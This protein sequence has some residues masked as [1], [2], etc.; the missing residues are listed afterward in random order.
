MYLQRLLQINIATLA[1]LG[2]LLLGMGRRDPWLPLLVLLAAITSVWLTDVTGWFRLNRTVANAAALVAVVLSARELRYFGGDQQIFSITNLLIYL[3]LIL[4][5]QEKDDRTYLQLVML[6]LLQVVV[7][8]VFSQGV[9]FGLLL[10]VY[11]LVGLSALALLFLY[12]QWNRY[13]PAAELPPSSAGDGRWPLAG[14][15]STFTSSPAGRGRGGVGRELFGRLGMMGLGTLALTILLFFT[16]PRFGRTAYRGAAVD[17]RR[18]VGFSDTVTLGELGSVIESREEVMR[19]WLTDQPGST[20][21][22]VQGELYL[23]GAI[24]THYQNGQWEYRPARAK[25][26]P[27]APSP[28]SLKHASNVSKQKGLSSLSSPP[29]RRVIRQRIDVEPLDRDDLFCIWPFVRLGPDDNVEFDSR[30][31]R[32]KRSTGLHAQ[33][34]RYELGTTAMVDGVQ[35]E[36][37]PCDELPDVKPLLQLPQG[38]CRTELAR[39]WTDEAWP[40]ARMELAQELAAKFHDPKL[41]QYSLERQDRESDFNP[42][43]DPVVDFINNN[44]RGHCEYFAT[45]LALLL[46]TRGIPSRVVV[47][48]KCE[49]FNQAGE[50]YR[51]RQWH[52]HAWVEAYLEKQHLPEELLRRGPP[53][54][55][56]KG[57]WLRL[58][59]TPGAGMHAGADSSLLGRIKKAWHWI[60]DLWSDYIIEMD[61]QRQREAIYAPVARAV[62][63]AIS[64]LCDPHWWRGAIR[65][66]DKTLNLTQ[67]SG[68][69]W[70][71]VALMVLAGLPLLI[72]GGRLLRRV[73]GRLWGRLAGRADSAFGGRQA[74]VEFYRRLETLLARHGL[75]RSVGQTQHE[76]ATAAGT[77][78]AQITGQVRLASLP[79]QVAEAF[80]RVRFG[81]LPLDSPQAQ[82]VEHALTQLAAC[83]FV[84]CRGE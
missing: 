76:F 16:V 53:R 27:R 4:L 20:T 52:A 49:E 44:P 39:T 2:A 84:Q 72:F 21:Y 71:W 59:P 40:S 77:R 55:W 10:V 37:V 9:W 75:V 43:V 70:L 18:V 23:R 41:F 29:N 81:R 13:R 32:L 31:Q 35:E 11:M 46:R 74:E 36:L 3:Q 6:S 28:E 54:R 80:Y 26:G 38:A 14:R 22:P 73:L 65:K 24:L 45:A 48:Y 63:S 66:I 12:R 47:G 15:G 51:V 17:T 34:F 82:A 25:P 57:G 8:A 19:V 5:F 56:A 79:Q 64:R 7:A 1:A 69:Y 83:G 67:G 30:T 68:F 42:E 61:R 58:E 78:I 60:Q 33:R 62:H 50:F